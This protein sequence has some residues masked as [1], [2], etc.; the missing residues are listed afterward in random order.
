MRIVELASNLAFE[1]C[2]LVGVGV[3]LLVLSWLFLDIYLD[4]LLVLCLRDDAGG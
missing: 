3:V 2:N 4:V 1:F